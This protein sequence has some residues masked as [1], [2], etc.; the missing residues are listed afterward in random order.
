M[1]GENIDWKNDII[2]IQGRMNP[3]VDSRVIDNIIRE[4]KYTSLDIES[5]F[6]G[7]KSNCISPESS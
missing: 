3:E 2:E 5:I 4:Y 6:C 1:R 7:F